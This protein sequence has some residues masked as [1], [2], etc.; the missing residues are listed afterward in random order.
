MSYASRSLGVW[1]SGAGSLWP[2]ALGKTEG[3]SRMS[4][5]ILFYYS[6]SNSNAGQTSDSPG[7]GASRHVPRT[8]R[9]HYEKVAKKLIN[10]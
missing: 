6:R 10:I 3:A 1:A 2:E 9:C 5:Q 4:G 8:Y 7:S